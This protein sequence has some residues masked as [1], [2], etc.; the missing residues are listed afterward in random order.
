MPPRAIITSTV[1][2]TD[3]Q[4]DEVLSLAD[5]A[6]SVDGAPPLNEAATLHLRHPS[7]EVHHLS[8]VLDD[9]LVGYAQLEF[10]SDAS[11]VQLVVD[12]AVRRQGLGTQLAGEVLEIAAGHLALQAWSAGATPAAAALAARVQMVV[13]RELSIMTRDL[14]GGWPEPAAPA[15]VEIRAFR[16]GADESAWLAVNARAFAHHPEQGSIDAGD[17]AQRMAEPWFDPAGFLL[18][19]RAGT[20][21]GYHWTKQH[22]QHLGEVYVLAVDPQAGGAG[23]GKVLLGAGLR[24]L[25]NRGNTV[26]QLYVESDHDG[27]VGLYRQFG[28]RTVSRD[29]MYVLTAVSPARTAPRS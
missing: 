14:T 4:V 25:R 26:V 13:G 2:P 12:P 16:V 28:F 22:D 8:V 27:A 17:L 10:S 1:R 3:A 21:V 20:L 6:A 7:D 18:A 29:V 9:R 24:H 19:E 11:T 5:R 15:D 23:L